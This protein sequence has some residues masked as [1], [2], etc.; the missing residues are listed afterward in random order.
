MNVLVLGGGGREHALVR[1]LRGAPSVESLSCVPGNPGIARLASLPDVA[2]NDAAALRAYI[3]NASIDLVVPGPESFIAGG[4]AD[5]L[6]GARGGRT[7]VFAPSQAAA[8]VES[9]KMFGAALR[10]RAGIPAPRCRI[11]TSRVQAYAAVGELLRASGGVAVKADGLC[12]GKGVVVT[13]DEREARNAV[14]LMMRD[15]RFGDAGA[16]LVIEEQLRGVEVSVLAVCDGGRALPLVPAQDY[17]RLR[18]DNMGPNTGGMG[19]IAPAPFASAAWLDRVSREVLAPALATLA[20]MGTPYTG[21]LYAGLLL[22]ERDGDRPKVLEFNARF[23]DPEAQVVLPLF[24]GDFAELL[25]CACDGRLGDARMRTRPG[26]AVCVVVAAHGYP[27]SPRAGDPIEGV[28]A[29]EALGAHVYHAGT[30]M[31]GGRLVASGGRVL[32][33][34]ALGDTLADAARRAH[35]AA[36]EIRFEGSQRRRDIGFV[37]NS[38]RARSLS[39]RANG[40]HTAPQ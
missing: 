18:D 36:A 37:D 2:A 12:A 31:H 4:I 30:K 40:A 16:S 14:D 38:T 23:G 25:V 7:R 22:D 3:E 21:V 29:A 35:T 39:P 11:A 10:E 32:G 24:E 33:I 8:R 6:R 5:A 13:S 9:S 1:A 17:K 34:T 19:A 20:E 26:A 27:E 15:R 28:E